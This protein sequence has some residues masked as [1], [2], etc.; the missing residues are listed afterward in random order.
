M[1]EAG[2]FADRV[3]Q[4]AD[5]VRVV[6]EYVS[7]RKS[8]Q[9][10]VGL[11]PFHSERSPSFAVHPVKQI[12]HCFGCGVG[13]DVFKFVMELDKMQ[14]SGRGSRGGGKMRNRGA[15]A[16]R[17]VAR[18]TRKPISRRTVLV[19][20]HREAAA[21]FARQLDGHSRGKSRA[22]VSGGPRTRRRGDCALR[23]GLRAFRRR[24]AAAPSEAE[25]SG[26]A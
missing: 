16:A 10:F 21:F 19:E 8:G 4:Q 6:G 18:G 1:A 12:Y 26:K 5:I 7:L 3:K 14:F 2:S 25:I 24:S 23:P 15:A 20:M 22:R 9:N 17:A 13:G 11:C